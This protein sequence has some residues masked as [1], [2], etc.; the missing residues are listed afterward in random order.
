MGSLWLEGRSIA[1][2]GPW[3]Q[4]VL[5]VWAGV[6]WGVALVAVPAWGQGAGGT[7]PHR[8]YALAGLDTVVLGRHPRA[9]PHGRMGRCQS[10]KRL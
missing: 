5:F 9:R 7:K 3:L 8:L 1:G 6:V 10:W 2:H 4:A